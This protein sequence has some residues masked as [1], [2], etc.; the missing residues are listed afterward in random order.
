MTFSTP[1]TSWGPN[2]DTQHYSTYPPAPEAEGAEDESW[3]YSDW[4]HAGF[5]VAGFI[6]VW[7]AF[8]DVAEA[9]LYAINGEYGEAA[10]SLVFAIPGMGDA[11]ALGTKGAKAAAK[12][13]GQAFDFA[14]AGLKDGCPLFVPLFVPHCKQPKDG[15][16]LFVPQDSREIPHR[17]RK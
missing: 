14:K 17:G 15:C 6:P 8:F 5:F 9:A 16:P 4:L 10:M 3:T 2:Y 13:G 1:L 11:A 12:L 7:G